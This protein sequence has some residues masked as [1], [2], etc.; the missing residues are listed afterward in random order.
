MLVAAGP[1]AR[2][3]KLKLVCIEWIDA[4]ARPG[5]SEDD[6]DAPPTVLKTYGLLVRKDK[7]FVV[8][9]STFDPDSGRWG[10]RGKI[11]AGMVK[12]ITVLDRVD[13]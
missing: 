7:H 12:K 8:H 1:D 4:E 11:P 6:P 13:L 3:V 10:E 5:W 2:P 9:A